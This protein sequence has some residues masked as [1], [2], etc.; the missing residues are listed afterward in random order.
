MPRLRRNL[1]RGNEKR[2]SRWASDHS[3]VVSLS[4]GRRISIPYKVAAIGVNRDLGN[5]VANGRFSSLLRSF[6]VTSHPISDNA[7]LFVI[8]LSPSPYITTRRPHLGRS[9]TFRKLT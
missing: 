9:S 5:V 7:V 6:L 2:A 1:G 8:T 4:S 3:R